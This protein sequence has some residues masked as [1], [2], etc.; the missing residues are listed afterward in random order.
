LHFDAATEHYRARRFREAIHEFRL[1]IAQL[2]SA[3]LWFDIARAHE[4][5]GELG[6]AA[7]HYRLYLRDF[8]DAPDAEEV[9]KHIAELER[10]SVGS[11]AAHGATSGVLAI[12]AAAPGMLVLL[13]GARLGESPIDQVVPVAP[14]RHRLEAS[15]HG[16]IPFRADIEV[17][18]G[19]LSAAYVELRPMTRASAAQPERT[20]TWIAA[21]SSAAALIASG[22][23]GLLALD[24]RDEGAPDEARDL[25]LASDLALGGGIA[26]AVSAALL[27][28][29][30]GEPAEPGR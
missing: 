8:V 2:P 22:A 18:P 13:D 15:R 4:Q 20:W 28:F 10:R 26:L 14:G 30:E 17:Q 23:L 11:A 16:Y 6:A 12:D 27:Y 3:E 5:L 19:S 7:E 1:S 25:A 9:R 21:G 24:R 29:V